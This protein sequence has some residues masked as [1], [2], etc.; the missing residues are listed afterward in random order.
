MAKKTTTATTATVDTTAE[1]TETVQTPVAPVAQAPVM[2]P[3]MI[4]G[5]IR[6]VPVASGHEAE[7]AEILVKADQ[8]KEQKE[9]ARKAKIAADQ[10]AKRDAEKAARANDPEWLKKQEEKEAKRAGMKEILEKRKANSERREAKKQAELDAKIAFLADSG[11]AL[12]ID[13]LLE[14]KIVKKYAH[15]MKDEGVQRGW[16]WK[17]VHLSKSKREVIVSEV[18]DLDKEGVGT[19]E[20]AYNDARKAILDTLAELS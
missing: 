13:R 5:E 9:A 6:Y 4:D 18:I 7:A 3:V 16:A 15:G 19:L 20:T 10:K 14:A 11:S 17:V 1:G 8:T 12:P 2:I